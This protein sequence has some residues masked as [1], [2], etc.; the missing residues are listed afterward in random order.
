MTP[1]VISFEINIPM[2]QTMQFE[3]CFHPNLR[4]TLG[5]KKNL[6]SAGADFF[7]LCLDGKPIAETYFILTDLLAACEGG[8]EMEETGLAS[9]IGNDILYVFSLAVLSE[10]R[11]LGYGKILK[12]YFLGHIVSLTLTLD[13]MGK[14]G[15]RKI[16][17][18]ANQKAM[19]LNSMFG[20]EVICPYHN[21]YDTGETAYLYEI[22]I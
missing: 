16:I 17:G 1:G 4:G 15:V 12:S 5:E 8:P 14:Q 6:R 13:A 9:Y 3:K 21:W 19:C 7:Y 22:N 11:G 2:R 20:A 18:H 10:Y